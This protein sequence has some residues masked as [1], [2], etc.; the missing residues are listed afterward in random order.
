MNNQDNNC[1][2][3][4]GEIGLKHP[5]YTDNLFWI[6]C[7]VHPLTEGHILI[8]PKAHVSTMGSLS[9]DAFG[10][11]IE[12]YEKVKLFIKTYYG[13]VGIFEHGVTGQT[14][15]HAHTH[16]LPF[17]F[18]TEQIIPDE[19]TLHKISNLEEM[20]K[21]FVQKQKYLFLENKNQKWLV[22][23]DLGYP[24]FFRDIFGRLLGAEERSNWKTAENNQKL[25][26]EFEKDILALIEKWNKFNK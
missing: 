4:P 7:D 22:N 6:V 1:A 20:K 25:M 21:E 23:T 11:Y 8:I 5:L 10:K 17:N 15:F 12:L 9:E 2:H 24:R 13:E 18:N 14:V 19:K 16:F 26:L 3:C